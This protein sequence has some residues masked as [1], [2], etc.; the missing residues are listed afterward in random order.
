MK[1]LI[2]IAAFMSYFYSPI[3]A[4]YNN[5]IYTQ[6]GKSGT[7][8]SLNYD[9]CF[10]RTKDKNI[11]LLGHIG[12]GNYS[13]SETIDT[14]YIKGSQ[15]STNT[16]SI[17]WDILLNAAFSTNDQIIERK[18]YFEVNNLN[19]GGKVLLGDGPVNIEF[20][21]TGHLDF[22]NQ[23]IDVWDNQSAETKEYTKF[24][25]A[26]SMALK[27]NIKNVS[28]R[29]GAEMR[30]NYGKEAGVKFPFFVGIG[31]QF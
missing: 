18:Q 21:L 31:L 3:S 22:V 7:L 20:G 27:C 14:K 28:C 24:N 29:L 4:Q 26:P 30:Q 5:H 10:Y 1:K 16:G 8:I 11:Q 19:M 9:H 2:F 23:N 25:I 6:F 12:F 17:L 15:V 13:F